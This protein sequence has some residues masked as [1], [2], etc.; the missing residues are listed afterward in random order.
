VIREPQSHT[1]SFRN[2][3]LKEQRKAATDDV[4]YKT[5]QVSLGDFIETF[6]PNVLENLAITP[7]LDRMQKI[8]AWKEFSTSPSA[9]ASPSLENRITGI[10]QLTTLFDKMVEAAQH[11]W[12]ERCPKQRWSLVTTESSVTP[13]TPER[14][15]AIEPDAFF[16]GKADSASQSYTYYNIAFPAEFK[17]G[18]TSTANSLDVSPASCILLTSI[19]PLNRCQNISKVVHVMQH[20]MAVDARRRF[21]F[22][23][24]IENTSLALWYTNRSM[25]VASKPLDIF[26]VVIP[27]AKS[28]VFRLSLAVIAQGTLAQGPPVLCICIR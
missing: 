20:I 5:T 8:E 24:T 15:T 6:V 17:C 4:W 22:G 25:L 23:I 2:A 10:K 27:F 18:G 19:P 13:N 12:K 3:T 16:Y 28:L 11:V 9:D 1:P 21:T 14:P 26:K 7:V